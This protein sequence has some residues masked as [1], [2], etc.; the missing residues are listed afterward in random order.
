MTKCLKLEK[1]QQPLS[2]D[3][4]CFCVSKAFLKKFKIFLFFF[5]LQI[6]IFSVFSDHFN[7]LISKIIFLKIKKYILF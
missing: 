5:L 3:P 2:I 1:F 7:A 4:V 6:N